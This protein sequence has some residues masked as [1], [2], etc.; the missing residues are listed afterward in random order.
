MGYHLWLVPAGLSNGQNS[1]RLKFFLSSTHT[2]TQTLCEWLQIRSFWSWPMAP[3]E[4]IL[5]Q[6]NKTQSVLSY[7]QTLA[8][9]Y[10]NIWLWK[11]WG[12]NFMQIPMVR[13]YSHE[14]LSSQKKKKLTVRWA[15]NE[16]KQQSEKVWWSLN[17]S[18]STQT[19]LDT[20]QTTCGMN[21]SGMWFCFQEFLIL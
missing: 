21:W 13:V 6:N 1:V 3:R 15:I 11:T 10:W 7:P 12:V 5:E 14:C 2:Q 8:V 17:D 18:G 16:F 19:L 9:R 20:T 4:H